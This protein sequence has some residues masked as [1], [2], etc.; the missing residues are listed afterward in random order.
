MISSMAL[1][2]VTSAFCFVL[3]SQHLRLTRGPL[4]STATFRASLDL[5]EQLLAHGGLR[6]VARSVH[7]RLFLGWRFFRHYIDF[8][9]RP[10]QTPAFLQA[11]GVGHVGHVLILGITFSCLPFSSSWTFY[12]NP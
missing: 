6:V 4:A 2:F 3:L 1:V 7:G 9:R 8:L 12:R 10:R 11:F 5:V